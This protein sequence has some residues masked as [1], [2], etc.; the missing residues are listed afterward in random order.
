[1][2]P[3]IID[4]GRPASLRSPNFT[5][6]FLTVQDAVDQCYKLPAKDREH[7]VLVLHDQRVYQPGEI[8]RLRLK[9][10]ERPKR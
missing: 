1:M 7:A 9:A 4:C 2:D 5:T 10:A 6:D 3:I 8:P